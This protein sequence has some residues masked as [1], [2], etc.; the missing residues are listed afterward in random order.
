VCVCEDGKDGTLD[1]DSTLA[2]VIE[3][4]MVHLHHCTTYLLN[5]T[6]KSRTEAM[7]AAITANSRSCSHLQVLLCPPVTA[8]ST[9]SSGSLTVSICNHTAVPRKRIVSHFSLT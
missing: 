3:S 7:R 9:A 5:A 8:V 2:E 1:K 4:R 6:Q